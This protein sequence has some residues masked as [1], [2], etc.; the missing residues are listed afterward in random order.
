M[1]IKTNIK[2]IRISSGMK[3]L[4]FAKLLGISQQ[5][6]QQSERL[7]VRTIRLAKKYAKVLKCNPFEILG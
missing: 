3:Q 6:L 2:R 5:S 7:G 1:K 4:E